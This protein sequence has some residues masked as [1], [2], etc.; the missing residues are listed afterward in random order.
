MPTSTTVEFAAKSVFQ[1]ELPEPERPSAQ[2]QHEPFEFRICDWN[3]HALPIPMA[4]QSDM[5]ARV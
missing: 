1:K 3:K 4:V 5:L 2:F